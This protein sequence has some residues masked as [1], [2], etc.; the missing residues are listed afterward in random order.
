MPRNIRE[1]RRTR[2]VRAAVSATAVVCALT[3]ALPTTAAAKS[4]AAA[5][6]GAGIE[7]ISV[8]TSGT[9]GDGDSTG[10]TITADGRRVAFLSAATNLTSD[11]PSA[12]AKVF[13][14][15]QR[16]GRTTRMSSVA[17]PL[18]PPVISGDGEYVAFYGLIQ[19]YTHVFLSKVSL[20]ATIGTNCLALH[21]TQPT[22]STDGRY[23][24]RVASSVT[25]PQWQR[26]ERYDRQTDTTQTVFTFD[27]LATARPSLSGDGRFVAYQNGQT[28]DVYVW[29]QTDDTST[30]PIE[31]PAEAASLV[32]ISKDGKK[33]V[34]LSG[35]DTYVYDEVA[36]TAQLVPDARGVAI[37]PTGRYLL[38][39][40]PG[41]SGPA[42]LTLR[43]LQTGTD[44]TVSDR[45]A[46]AGTDAVSAYGRDV[47][48]SSAATDLVPDD[49]N[50][51]ADVFVRR[52][53]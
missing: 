31:G 27:H 1:V 53:Y 33:V 39:A 8:A 44:E 23:L 21:C 45:P 49:T 32:Q 19:R 5:S 2:R 47:V 48:F 14:R 17:A 51:K 12:A 37:D 16:A 38:Y 10:A 42:S 46:T 50:G 11:T 36:E 22:L 30:G 4:G 28:Q 40:P 25:A 43:D 3:A 35:S 6:G 34:Y 41:T 7:R 52:F 29:D 18:A 15:D 9:Q 20:G 24:A 26:V 13:V